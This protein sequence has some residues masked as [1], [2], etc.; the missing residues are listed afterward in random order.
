MNID[1]LREKRRYL[2]SDIAEHVIVLVEKFKDDIGF[3]PYSITIDMVESTAIGDKE[4]QYK[5]GRC[6]VDIKI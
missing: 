5:V 6:D 1:D 2:E 3:C 4:P